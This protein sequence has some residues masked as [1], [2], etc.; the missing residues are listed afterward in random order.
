MPLAESGNQ[1]IRPQRDAFGR[2]RELGNQAPK[3]CLWQNQGIRE[4][5]PK[6]M[7]LAE[8]GN[9]GIRPQRDA[10]GRIRELGN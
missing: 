7:P 9:Q 1:G 5:G 6:G 10:F 2:I 3:G 4:S 8:S